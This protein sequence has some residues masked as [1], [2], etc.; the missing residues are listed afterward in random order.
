MSDLDYRNPWAFA[1]TSCGKPEGLFY[2]W[3]YDWMSPDDMPCAPIEAL[4][5]WLHREPC[6]DCGGTS[7]VVVERVSLHFDGDSYEEWV[8]P[9]YEDCL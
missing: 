1:T 7:C 4:V 6:Q 9:G 3:G 8:A 5:E 2:G